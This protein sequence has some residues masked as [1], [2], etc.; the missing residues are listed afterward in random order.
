MRALVTGAAGF[1]GSHLAVRL[2][3]DGWSVDGVDSFTDYYSRARKEDN[4]AVLR[5]AGV[6]LLELDLNTVPLEPLLADVDVVFHQAGQPGVRKSWGDNFSTYTE[7]NVNATQKLLEAARSAK[8]LRRFVYAS[9]SSVYGDAERFPTR[10]SDLPRPHSPYGVTKLAAEHLCVL[11]ARNFDV[12]TVSLRYFTVYGPRQRPDM[13]FTRF[14]TAAVEESPIK[15][16]GDGNQIRDFTYVEDVVSANLAVA[17]STRVAPG[18]VFN[19]AG[20]S[21]ISVNGVLG[22]IREIHGSELHV[23][24]L[25]RVD[26][27]VFRTGG[28]TAAIAEATGWAPTVDIREGLSRHYQWAAKGI[29]E[30]TLV[31]L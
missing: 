8:K 9:S 17:E 22:H 5:A 28:S 15:I 14:V 2:A 7:A 13:A 21:S 29:A 12:P 24:Y 10:E 18:A 3:S 25:P 1:V 11:Y 31:R 6:R 16:F 19:V 4:A 23:D 27:D 30:G 26:G 20:G